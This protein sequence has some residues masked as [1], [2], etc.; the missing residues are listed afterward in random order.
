MTM[1]MVTDTVLLGDNNCDLELWLMTPHRITVDVHQRAYSEVVYKKESYKKMLWA[2]E[3][4]R[5]YIAVCCQVSLE[6]VP[7]ILFCCLYCTIMLDIGTMKILAMK[8]II[9]HEGEWTV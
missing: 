9:C 4:K 7:S 3:E 2:L 5:P 8:T 1:S 6:E